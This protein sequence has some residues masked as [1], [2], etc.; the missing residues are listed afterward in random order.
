MLI[1]MSNN[2]IWKINNCLLPKERMSMHN[3]IEIQCSEYKVDSDI[4]NKYKEL[5][6]NQI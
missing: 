4:P 3:S 6:K 2:A 1:K 5:L